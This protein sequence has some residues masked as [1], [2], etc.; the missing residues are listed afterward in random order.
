[1][2]SGAANSQ[3]PEQVMQRKG[4]N[5]LGGERTVKDYG[6]CIMF[7]FSISLSRK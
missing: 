6:S 3:L 5:E 7:P 2:D 4:I 1:M